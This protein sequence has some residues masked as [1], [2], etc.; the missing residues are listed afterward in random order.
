MPL[1]PLPASFQP[2]DLFQYLRYTQPHPFSGP[3]L[4]LFLSMGH[5]L[6]FIITFTAVNV[7]SFFWYRFKN[8]VFREYW[9][10]C[11]DW[12]LLLYTSYPLIFLAFIIV[13]NYIHVGTFHCLS[14]QKECRILRGQGSFLFYSLIFP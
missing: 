7:C 6:P 2:L 12:F 3:L 5:I 8:S 4:M 10:P 11:L 13:C 9:H 14:P 1:E